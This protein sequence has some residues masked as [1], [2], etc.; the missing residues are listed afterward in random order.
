MLIIWIVSQRDMYHFLNFSCFLF[1]FSYIALDAKFLLL[2]GVLLFTRPNQHNK[3]PERS[4]P[5]EFI[6]SLKQGLFL[7]QHLLKYFLHNCKQ[8]HELCFL[9]SING[10]S[11]NCLLNVRS[12]TQPADSP[13]QTGRKMTTHHEYKKA[14]KL[15]TIQSPSELTAP[16]HAGHGAAEI[17]TLINLSQNLGKAKRYWEVTVCLV[18]QQSSLLILLLICL[19]ASGCAN[20]AQDQNTHLQTWITSNFGSNSQWSSYT[21]LQ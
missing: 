3:K 18:E 20:A 19:R 15:I 12:L 11:L 8:F 5:Q 1:F 4:A 6:Y 17:Q 2:L 10:N 13:K 21:L 14:F 9:N 16:A 7:H